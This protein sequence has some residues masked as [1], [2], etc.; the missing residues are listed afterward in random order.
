MSPRA[1]ERAS[2]LQASFR[3][4]VV[5]TVLVNHVTC[6]HS[7][8]VVSGKEVYAFYFSCCM[9]VNNTSIHSI[10]SRSPIKAYTIYLMS[11]VHRYRPLDT[12]L[13]GAIQRDSR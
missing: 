9:T 12:V 6:S 7:L 1:C 2:T 4:V 3:L 5:N 10:P 13:A 8:A 11:S